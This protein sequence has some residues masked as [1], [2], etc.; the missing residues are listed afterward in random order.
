MAAIEQASDNRNTADVATLVNGTTYYYGIGG[1]ASMIKS[2]HILGL[3]AALIITAATIEFS[4]LPD[5]ALNSTTA[6]EWVQDNGATTNSG[7]VGAGW[8]WTAKTLAVAGGAL[9]GAFLNIADNAMRRCRLKVVVGAT[10]GRIRVR[11]H[12]AE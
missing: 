12:G 10:G 4:N 6:G 8:T 2:L 3:D 1:D 7:A 5:V 11:S 9:G